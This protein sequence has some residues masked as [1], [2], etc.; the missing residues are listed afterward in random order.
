M[1]RIYDVSLF[2]FIPFN[3]KGDKETEYII[4]TIDYLLRE[5]FIKQIPEV[6]LLD[7]VEQL[8]DWKVNELFAEFH[9]DYYNKNVSIEQ[10]RELIKTSLL[11]H[12]T[13][14]TPFA[15]K[16]I[17]DILFKN[18]KVMEWFD[19]DGDPYKFKISTQSDLKNQDD[20]DQTIQAI[21]IYKN[22][23][24][25]LESIIFNRT[26]DMELFEAHLSQK[27]V[28]T[29]LNMIELEFPVEN[30][31]NHTGIATFEHRKMEIR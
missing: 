30:T 4:E 23:R 10:K 6:I 3:F 26:D 14:G 17:T 28:K 21:E 27:K 13:K 2:D 31:K 1:K 8:E 22:A 29:V 16:I 15:L 12:R 9:V 7:R 20:Y 18:G 24:S 25:W 19:Y 11:T 5:R